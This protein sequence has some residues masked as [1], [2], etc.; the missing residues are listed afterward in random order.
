M[1]KL[2]L[3]TKNEEQER[4]K[5]Y[6]EENASEALITKINEGIEI[7][8]DNK[9]VVNKKDLDGFMNFAYEEASKLNTNKN[10]VLAIS[11]DTVF[12]WA[13]HYFEEGSIEGTLYNLD[14]T[15]YKP[16]VKK[17]EKPKVEHKPVIKV[18]PPKPQNS[19]GSFFEMFNEDTKLDTKEQNNTIIEETNENIQNA[20]L[21]DEKK[22]ESMS[23]QEIIEYEDPDELFDDTTE[24][25]PVKRINENTIIDLKTGEVIIETPTYQEEYI[26]KLKPLLGAILEVKL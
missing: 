17:E 6:L 16:V 25:V 21:L 10:R 3:A 8:K 7:V 5:A 13:I 23:Y 14:G 20:T 4:I 2:N 15:E 24:K 18:E 1:S 26:S 12:G 9:L 22:Q 11:K 19:Q